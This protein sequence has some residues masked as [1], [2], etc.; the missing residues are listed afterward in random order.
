MSL[1]MADTEFLLGFQNLD[2]VEVSTENV[3]RIPVMPVGTYKHPSA[4]ELKITEE[5]LALLAEDINQRG[6]RIPVDFDHSFRRGRGSLAAGWFRRGSAMVENG[7]LTAEVE[8]TADAAEDIRSKRYRFISPEWSFA[9]KTKE[10]RMK[11]PSLM[12][13]ALTNRPFF[14]NMPAVMLA[15]RGLDE[16]LRPAPDYISDED[17]KGAADWLRSETLQVIQAEAMSGADDAKLALISLNSLTTRL[18]DRGAKESNDEGEEMDISAVAE[19]VGLAADAS[20]EDV[21]TALAEM[22]AKADRAESLEADVDE[23]KKKLP[24]DGQLQ[25]LVASAAKGEE[26]AK[27][28]HDM[29]RETLLAEA[30]RERKILPAQKEHYASLYDVDP[31]GV[32]KLIEATASSSFAPI[33]TD[34]DGESKGDIS[35]AQDEFKTELTEHVNADSLTIHEKALEILKGDGKATEHNDN[36]YAKAVML[37]SKELGLS[38]HDSL[39]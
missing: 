33:G 2:D 31:A 14:E 35:V 30:V 16:I 32:T 24:Q 5:D 1:S 26:A 36:D 37:A 20:E 12:A 39:A 11:M 28:L 6:D 13:A 7:L 21:E 15:D 34:G 8:W 4:G 19:M 18:G 38:V 25:A 23:L 27:E 3:S 17:V 22:K 29:K 10:A 9:S